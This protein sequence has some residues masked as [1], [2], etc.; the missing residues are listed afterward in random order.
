[1]SQEENTIVTMFEPLRA[2][3][4]LAINQ[5]RGSDLLIA[6][7]ESADTHI[8]QTQALLINRQNEDYDEYNELVEQC[9]KLQVQLLTVQAQLTDTQQRMDEG[10]K[11]LCDRI[12]DLEFARDEALNK[13]EEFR[14]ALKVKLL[15]ESDL[16]AENHSLKSLNPQRQ[17][18]QLARKSKELKEKNAT[19]DK[20]ADEARELRKANNK[21]KADNLELQDHNVTLIGKLK[22]AW[23]N[24]EKTEGNVHGQIFYGYKGTEFFI[25]V[26]QFALKSRIQDRDIVLV[27]KLP[28]HIVVRSTVGVDLLVQPTEWC[29]P[30]R[31]SLGLFKG[32]WPSELDGGLCDR[33][34]SLLSESH[35][36][37]VERALWADS[38]YIADLGLPA[39]TL[40]ALEAGNIPTLRYLMSHS[41][42]T[43][44]EMKGMSETS[45]RAAIALGRKRVQEWEAEHGKVAA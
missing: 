10:Q 42:A 5:A 6:V 21:L 26:Y 43:L 15:V 13:A 19:I 4:K 28:W 27:D 39:R 8:N 31:S 11:E 3:I 34:V 33:I 23:S 32:D 40:S 22:T 12:A 7:L 37:L 44:S 25:Y 30:V 14:Q 16:K 9:E 38:I 45:A 17:A 1:M 20:Q 29:T 36:L 41:P 35:P 2:Q 24:L 18:D